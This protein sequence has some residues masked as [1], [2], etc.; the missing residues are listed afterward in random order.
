[1]RKKRMFVLTDPEGAAVTI[2]AMARMRRVLVA[3]IL[4]VVRKLRISEDVVV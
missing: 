3:T 4:D 2:M 1:M